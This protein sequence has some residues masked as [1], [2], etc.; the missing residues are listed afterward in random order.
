[1]NADAALLVLPGRLRRGLDKYVAIAALSFR[2]RLD[3]RAVLLGRVM[4]YA[5]ILAIYSRLWRAALGGSG[6]LALGDGAQ[7]DGGL[8]QSP[9]SYVWYLA[10]TEWI[11]LAQPSLYLEIEADVRNGD[12]AYQLSRPLSYVGAKLS[13]ALGELAL[14][15]LVLGASGLALGRLFSGEW[16]N[17][18]GLVGALLVGSLAGLVMLLA[19]AAIGLA[20]FW[21]H[22]VTPIFLIWQKLTFVLG[23]LML[24]IS[25]YPAWLRVV[26][27]HTPFA[28]LLYGPGQLVVQGGADDVLRLSLTLAAW[29][30]LFLMIV[31]WLERRARRNVCLHGG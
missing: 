3:D 27:E 14:R 12:V 21:I 9:G 29:G 10:V 17:P 8:G 15:W 18:E 23:G 30:A 28:A 5:I 2:Q 22:D 1:M 4:F 7:G 20:A 6:A 31:V 16:P 24:P 13:A 11:I 25:I 26:A 19:Y